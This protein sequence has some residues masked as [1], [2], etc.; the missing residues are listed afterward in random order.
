MAFNLVYD[1]LT[2]AAKA[3][4]LKDLLYVIDKAVTIERKSWNMDNQTV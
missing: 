2:P 1:E 4:I 3:K